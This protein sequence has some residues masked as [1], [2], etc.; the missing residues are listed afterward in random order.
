MLLKAAALAARE[1]PDLNGF[2]SEDHFTPGDGVHLG[3][4]VSLRG[5][6]LIAPALHAADALELGQLMAKLR[7][8]VSRARG[9]RLR[10]AEVSTATLTV[11]SLGDQG[12][13][14]YSVSS[15]RLRWRSSASVA[16]SSG[17]VP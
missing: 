8:L 16:S 4:A 7:D 12:W 1:V 5:G 6:G 17:R 14:P 11:T 10:G 9:G 13:R 15:T 3:V 2:W